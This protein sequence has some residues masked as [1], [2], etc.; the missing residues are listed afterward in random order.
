[1]YLG[2]EDRGRLAGEMRWRAVALIALAGIAAVPASSGAAQVGHATRLRVSVKPPDGSIRTHF[3]VSFRA[4]LSTGPSLHNIYRITASG[5]VHG[6]CQSS[7]AAAAPATHAGSTVRVVLSPTRSAGWCV[8][9]FRG[10][11]WDVISEGCPVGKACPLIMP[12]PQMVGA[13]TFHVARG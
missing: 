12:A 3:V 10:Q 6:G 9:T 4:A 13:F 1:M 2:P 7:G 11:V 8:G 5:P